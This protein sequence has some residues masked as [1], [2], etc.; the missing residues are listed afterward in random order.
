MRSFLLFQCWQ[1][2]RAE[3]NW[4]SWCHDFE[5]FS[6]YFA[7]IQAMAW[8]MWGAFRFGCG[9]QRVTGIKFLGLSPRET[10]LSSAKEACFPAAPF[11]PVQAWRWVVERG[12][13]SSRQVLVQDMIL[14]LSRTSLSS[15]AM[16]RSSA[17]SHPQDTANQVP[18]RQGIWHALTHVLAECVE[19]MRFQNLP[20]LGRE[21]VLLFAVFAVGIVRVAKDGADPT[22][23]YCLLSAY[24]CQVAVQLLMVRRPATKNA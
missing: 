20:E 5:N 1:H 17:S 13:E 10:C 24:L 15:P 14:I 18:P 6:R 19:K 4:E 12:F 21:R 3:G 8:P 22:A 16:S 11:G 23:C 9:N 2:E 7:T